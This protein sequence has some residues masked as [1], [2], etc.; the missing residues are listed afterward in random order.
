MAA[1]ESPVIFRRAP[2]GLPRA[3]LQRFAER[4]S[5]EVSGG[6]RFTCLVADDRQLR[7]LNRQFLG[8]DY[9]ADVLSFPAAEPGEFLGEMA[10]SVQR[11][12]E[13][14]QRHG[15]SIEHEI[16]VLMLHG[17]LHLMGM[18]HETDRGRM[19]R[20]EIKYR[21]RLDLPTGLIER[22]RP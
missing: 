16:G 21:K 19:K 22:A 20:T 14:A 15:H 9:P 5:R 2:R 8:R 18:D 4:L 11:A 10:I 3:A 13:Q 7:R 1:L 17:V 12:R 6:R